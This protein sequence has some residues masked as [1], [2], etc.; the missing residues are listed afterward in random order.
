[1]K[2]DFSTRRNGFTLVE[3]L[4]V[5]AI[6]G[7]LVGMLFPAIQA[8]REAARRTSCLNN[9]RQLGIAL[10]NYESARQH[11]P[12]S[13]SGPSVFVDGNTSHQTTYQSW[14]VLILPYI[15]QTNLGGEFNFNAEWCDTN[16]WIGNPMTN[17]EVC[18][19][20]LQ[21][22]TC[23]SAPE[24]NRVDPNHVPEVA[25]G[26]YGSINEV[27]SR[28]Y[29]DVLGIPDP[30]EPSRAGVLSKGVKN[31]MQNIIDG[32]SNS[33]MIAECGGQPQVWTSRGPMDAAMY[34]NYTDDK[35]EVFNG[36]YVAAD[37][38]GWADPDCG[39]SI[40]GASSDGLIKYGPRMINAI[41]VSEV[42]AFHTG[43]ANF[44]MADGSGRFVADN[45]DALVMVAMTTRAGREVANLEN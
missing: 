32:T 42:F 34:A 2:R 35:V 10:H 39:F 18:S 36:R 13:R 40:N 43:G 44:C 25:A 37:G 8:V 41:N 28:V 15:E 4:V 24:S 33:F 17:R 5:I 23:P 45:I 7:I 38:T 30:G 12:P 9:I 20:Q 31:P 1:M 29:T 26:D 22:F 21:I 19:T 11:F 16:N 3:L 27:K 14:T 6:I